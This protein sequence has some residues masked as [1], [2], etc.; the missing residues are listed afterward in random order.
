MLLQEPFFGS[1]SSLF[2]AQ[3]RSDSRHPER[4]PSPRAP[5]PTRGSKPMASDGRSGICLIDSQARG[6]DEAK[7]PAAPRDLD[8]AC[9]A[10]E[11]GNA[12]CGCGPV[13][14]QHA[15]V[16]ASRLHESSSGRA[17]P[18]R[19]R[20]P[21]R[22]PEGFWTVSGNSRRFARRPIQKSM[23]MRVVWMRRFWEHAVEHPPRGICGKSNLTYD[24]GAHP[25]AHPCHPEPM[26]RQAVFGAS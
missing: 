23:P 15:C 9:H 2:L 24:G 14:P 8:D 13:E 19:A 21:G 11:E 22:F 5:F 1:S 3:A 25:A 7:A 12:G 10:C 4:A 16:K 20:A 18:P 17:P 26:P 6:K